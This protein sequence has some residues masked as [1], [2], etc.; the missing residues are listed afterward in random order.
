MSILF[1]NLRGVPADEADDVRQLLHT[2]N[3]NFYETSAGIWGISTPAIWLVDPEELPIAQGL[4]DSYQQ[5][6]SATQRALYQET[7]LQNKHAG[8]WLH[9][10]KNPI[11]FVVICCA[12]SLVVYLSI[13]W[14]FDLGL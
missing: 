14:V 2:N 9:N 12:I 13:K 1:F 3:I 7:K 11:R 10:L 4:F 8:F 6:R 5:H